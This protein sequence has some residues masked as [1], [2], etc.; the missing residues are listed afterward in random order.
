VSADK[1]FTRNGRYEFDAAQLPEAHARCL[2]AFVRWAQRDPKGLH[3]RNP[4]MCIVDNTNTT[5]AEIAPYYAL[6]QAY[7]HNVHIRVF[8]GEW[9]N[10]HGVPPDVIAAQRDRL[11]SLPRLA[12]AWWRI[13]YEGHLH[14]HRPVY[15]IGDASIGEMK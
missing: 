12:P 5:V 15:G 3:T 6:A 14:E 7:G 4:A 13:E 2:L 9:A 10:V 1:F 11:Q 8:R